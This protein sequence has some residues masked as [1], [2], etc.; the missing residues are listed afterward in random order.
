MAAP[1]NILV[2]QI[3]SLGDTIVSIPSYRAIRRHFG[4]DATIRVLHN[5]PVGQRATPND[6]LSSTGLINGSV[7]YVQ[8]PSRLLTLF[9]LWRVMLK[10]KADSIVYVLPGQRPPASVQRDKQFFKFCGVKSQI[11]FESADQRMFEPRSENVPHILCRHESAIRLDRL[12]NDGI[13][14][15][16]EDMSIPLIKFSDELLDWSTEWL[17]SKSRVGEVPLVAIAPGAN[18]PACIW[19]AERY[20][21]L[22][23][24][25]SGEGFQ[26]VLVG[27]KLET[28][29]GETMAKRIPNSINAAGQLTVMQTAA[30]INQTKL[31]I[32]NDT[33]TSHLAAAAGT[34]IIAVFS[35]QNVAGQ[36]EPL[37][38]GN[39]IIRRSVPCGGC[40]LTFC[41]VPGHPCM[42][43]ITVDNVWD[44]VYQKLIS[45]A[46]SV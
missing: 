18:K 24:R 40:R 14:V 29:L 10:A 26:V 30:I 21:E 22:S 17:R 1:K 8:Y 35:D 25:L 31:F 23:N 41:N 12:S 16:P 42:D 32:G 36:W 4:D 34:P 13:R 27:G 37:G 19:P 3:G 33:G 5:V 43:N 11:G 46:T 7:S 9:G 20:V 2:Y 39:I 6:I 45:S 44:I 15:E 28:Q 38:A